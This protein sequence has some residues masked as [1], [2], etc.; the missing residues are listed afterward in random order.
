MMGFG[1]RIKGLA[2]VAGVLGLLALVG[3]PTPDAPPTVAWRLPAL[4]DVTRIEVR[5]TGAADVLIERTPGGWRTGGAPLDPAALRALE[6]VL[7]QPVGADLA[8]AVQDA[9]LERFGLTEDALTVTV[10]GPSTLTFRIGKAVDAQ[11]TFVLP[12]P[13]EHILRARAGLRRAFDRE[14]WLDRRLF[15]DT[16]FKDVQTLALTRG[17]HPDW[18]VTRP[19]PDAPFTLEGGGLIDPDT[20]AGIVNT[21]AT[22]QASGFPADAT[23]QPTLHFEGRTFSGLL[24]KLDYDPRAGLV[25]RLPDG[26]IA[27]LPGHLK[28]F[29]DVPSAGLADRRLFPG[30]GLGVKAVVIGGANPL[31]LERSEAGWTLDGAPLPGGATQRIQA[32]LDARAAGVIERVPP[33]AFAQPFHTVI[34]RLADDRQLALTVGGEFQGG[35]RYVRNIEGESRTFVVSPGVLKDLMPTREALTAP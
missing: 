10:V 13:G 22:L 34:V 19:T 29:L 7:A 3:A 5:R 1:K 25:R 18:A 24:L 2:L 35:S 16:T 11:R 30:V 14:A 15:G 23:L 4:T 21:F 31:R 6:E 28:S 26:L 33:D 8:D 27:R 32:V 9:A 12:R 20:V 17:P